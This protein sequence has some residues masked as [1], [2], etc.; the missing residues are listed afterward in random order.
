MMKGSLKRLRPT[1]KNNPNKNS[2]SALPWL[3]FLTK[4]SAPQEL[5]VRFLLR[6][7]LVVARGQRRRAQFPWFVARLGQRIYLWRLC[8]SGLCRV[9]LQLPGSR[10][11]AVL[12][13]R[14]RQRARQRRQ[15]KR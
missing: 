8:L 1:N 6:A 9:F 15:K 2:Q 4:I 3:F 7:R 13:L 5:A 14:V 11:Y 12:C 10:L